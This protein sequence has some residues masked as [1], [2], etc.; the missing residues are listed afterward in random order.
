M[1]LFV[2]DVAIAACPTTDDPLARIGGVKELELLAFKTTEGRGRTSTSNKAAVEKAEAA[3]RLEATFSRT[4]S[5]AGSVGIK[6]NSLRI[7]S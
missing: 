3:D 6:C 2:G 4:S 5:T 1:V 7:V